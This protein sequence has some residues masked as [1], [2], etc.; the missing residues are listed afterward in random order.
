MNTNSNYE[1]TQII[2]FEKDNEEHRQAFLNLNTEWLEKYFYVE[3]L[4][5]EILSNPEKNVINTGGSILFAKFNNEIIGTGSLIKA[6][7][8]IFEL[9]KLSITEKYKGFGT[10]KKLVL[11]LIELAK[12]KGIKKLYLVSSRKLIPAITL[13]KKFGFIE[14][15]ENRHSCFERGNITMELTL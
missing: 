10:G 9:S 1:N 6:A 2:H 4:D 13:Y 5:R 14:S 7:D 3:E 11:A 15:E 8:G 12:E